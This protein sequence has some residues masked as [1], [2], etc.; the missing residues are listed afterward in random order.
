[1]PTLT[2]YLRAGYPGI[3]L[4]THEESRAYAE[5]SA[6][7]QSLERPLF[8]WSI[9]SGLTDVSKGTS[10]ELDEIDVLRLDLPP[11]AVLVLFDYH[12]HLS[13]EPHPPL[14]R[15]LK[16]A[17]VAAKQC[18]IPKAL[19]FVGCRTQFPAEVEKL[20][21]N[22]D[23]ELPSRETLA[24]V[25]TTVLSTNGLPVP[26]DIDPAVTALCGLTT[27][28]AENA[29]ALSLITQGRLDPATLYAE[30][31][32]AVKKTGLMEL[33][34]P[35]HS[36]A[37]IGG[38]D[39]IKAWLAERRD[40]FSIAARDYGIAPPRGILM[41]GLP[42]TGKTEICKGISAYLGLPLIRVITASI[43][44]PH[45]GETEA[46]FRL[47]KETAERIAPCILWFDEI[48]KAF[49]GV[50]SSGKTD[51][52]TLKRIFGELLTWMSEATKGVLIVASANDVSDLDP[53]LMRRFDETF[54]VDLP[55]LR[56][57]TEIWTIMARR[58]GHGQ[59]LKEADFAA[60]AAASNQW[61]GAEIKGA[62]NNALRLGY[63]AGRP[64]LLPQD[65]M[66]AIA[67]VTPLARQQP[68]KIK[69]L[70]DWSQG[71]CRPASTDATADPAPSTSPTGRKLQLG[72]A[73]K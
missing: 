8:H 17:L 37:D 21:V 26:P 10:Q 48:E 49:A 1:M 45:V 12:L 56:D 13:G 72:A 25:L 5:I 27:T 39:G 54:W 60:F 34:Q 59:D 38:M 57:R 15:A 63:R 19:I 67:N 29:V 33:H 73:H 20:I 6:A 69:A 62:Y 61:T 4:T 36:L 52:G 58:Y 55:S 65:V 23:L 42:G 9:S 40:D 71:R 50:E 53:A 66:D 7:A 46:N 70:R 31:A 2:H 35:A 68:D 44:A 51:G 24:T 18:D 32:S 22:I 41:A 3:A 14:V 16:E 47:V 43:M 30:K 28:E 64:H 11:G